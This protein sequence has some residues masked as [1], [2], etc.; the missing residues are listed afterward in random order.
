MNAESSK[1]ENARE[2]DRD[3]RAG[4]VKFLIDASRVVK[5]FGGPQRRCEA[6]AWRVRFEDRLRELERPAAE[7]MQTEVGV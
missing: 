6:D 4:V 1:E 3:S 2:C 5:K 7:P